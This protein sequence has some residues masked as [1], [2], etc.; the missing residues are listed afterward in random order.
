MS[1]Q[2]LSRQAKRKSESPTAVEFGS[3][4]PKSDHGSNEKVQIDVCLI[5]DNPQ[6][7]AYSAE[8]L[9]WSGKEIATPQLTG[10]F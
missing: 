2:S 5:G 10:D 4:T 8:A 6:T 9:C 7:V 3:R 1:H